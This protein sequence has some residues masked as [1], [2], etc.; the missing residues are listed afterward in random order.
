MKRKKKEKNTE[1]V[2]LFAICLHEMLQWKIARKPQKFDILA[3]QRIRSIF[4][5]NFTLIEFCIFNEKFVSFTPFFIHYEK[6]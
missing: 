2:K 4:H 5:L 6:S 1:F 3:L